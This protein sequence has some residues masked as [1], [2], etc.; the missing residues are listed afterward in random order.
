MKELNHTGRGR[1]KYFLIINFLIAVIIILFIYHLYLGDRINI[2]TPYIGD[3]TYSSGQIDILLKDGIITN[4]YQTV[5]ETFA[6][7]LSP[8]IEIKN[9]GD[10]NKNII[11]VVKNIDV[12][13]SGTEITGKAEI[14]KLKNSLLFKLELDKN[15]VSKIKVFPKNENDKFVFAVIG[16]TRGSESPFTNKR[17]SYFIYR[18]FEKEINEI[19]PAFWINLGDMVNSGQPYQYRRFKEQIKNIPFPF[20]PVIGNHEFVNP[21][22]EKYFKALF[23]NTN[24]SFNYGNY[25]FIII[26]NSKGDFSKENFDWLEKDINENLKK[27]IIVFAHMPV[28]DPRPGKDYAMKNKDNAWHL[29]EIF[30]K[31]KIKYVFAGHLHGFAYAKRKGVEYYISAGGGAKLETKNDFYNYLLVKADGKKLEVEIRKL[32]PPFILSGFKRYY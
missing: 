17:G 8:V 31:N 2:N 14:K 5:F 29:E 26:D 10:S 27:Y 21:I 23:G 1:N 7:S 11:L 30:I 9:K 24:Y 13:N 22:G 6:K 15:S 4:N 3:S 12:E 28:F 16:D 19:K 25:H 18:Q 20:F 32:N